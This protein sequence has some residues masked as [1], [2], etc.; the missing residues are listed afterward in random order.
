MI[1]ERIDFTRDERRGGVK[2]VR[3]IRRIA[4]DG[5]GDLERT[6]ERALLGGVEPGSNAHDGLAVA[7]AEHVVVFGI[8]G[9]DRIDRGNEMHAAGRTT[10]S[11]DVALADVFGIEQEFEESGGVP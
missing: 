6:E 9:K 7:V 5:D 8:D 1:A 4:A 10:E 11:A 2:A 3:P